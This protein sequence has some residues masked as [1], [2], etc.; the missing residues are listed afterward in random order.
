MSCFNLSSERVKKPVQ[1][2]HERWKQPER[3]NSFGRAFDSRS[4]LQSGA[5]EELDSTVCM[6][7]EIIC[8]T[9]LRS[10]LGDDGEDLRD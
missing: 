7:F 6:F 8:W 2:F 3:M 10:G 5:R 4:I 1:R 9:G